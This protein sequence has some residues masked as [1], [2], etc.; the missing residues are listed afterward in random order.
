MVETHSFVPN[1]GILT[2]NGILGKL[3]EELSHTTELKS[4]A[5]RSTSRK[6]M[7]WLDLNQRRYSSTRNTRIIGKPKICEASSVRFEKVFSWAV[8]RIS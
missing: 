1:E 4:E 6:S 5:S 3:T 8:S 7:P 2:G